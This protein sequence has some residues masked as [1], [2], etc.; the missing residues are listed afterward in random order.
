[1]KLPLSWLA[2]Y[3]DLPDLPVADLVET[4]GRFGLEVDAIDTPGAGVTGTTIARVL[5]WE[6]HPDA[7]RL[8]V[9]RITHGDPADGVGAGGDIVELVCGASNFDTGDVVVHAGVGGSIPGL[10]PGLVLEA[11]ELRGVVSNGMLCSA[12][13]LELGEDHDGIMVLDPDTP[14]GVD[15]HEVLPLGEP[16]IDL[17]VKGA[18]GDVLSVLGVAR[19][20]AAVLDVASVEPMPDL[21]PV[22]AE[23]PGDPV[24]VVIE[25]PAGCSHFAALTL[26]DVQVPAASPWWL[27]QR[28]A[29]VGV[30]AIS[31]LVDI[32]NYVMM[33][34]GQPMHAYDADRLGGDLSV[35]WADDGEVLVTLDDVE[36][37]L[38]TRDLVVADPGGPVGLAGVMGG[39]ATEVTADTRRLVLEAAIWDPPT[40]RHTARSLR[41]TSEASLRFER[42]VDP[43]GARRAIARAWELLVE[44]GGSATPVGLREAGQPI[45]ARETI[46]VD[47][48]RIRGLLGLDV[49]AEEQVAL[50][51]RAGVL[52]VAAGD[53]LTVTP[54]SWRSDLTRMADVAEEVAR[55]HGFDQIPA[56]L[57]PLLQGGGLADDQQAERDLRSAVLAFG[58]DEVITRPFVGDDHLRGVVPGNDRVVLANP[59]TQDAAAMRPSLLEGLLGVVRRN[60]GQSRPGVA[61]VEFGRIFRRE[62]GPLDAVLD[63]LTPTDA[64][65]WRWTLPPVDTTTAGSAGDPGAADDRV[66]PTQPR[67]VGVAL[68]GRRATSSRLDSR[69]WTV[70]EALAVFDEVA[71]R[72]G[73]TPDSIRLQRVPVARDGFHPHRTVAL[74]VEGHDGP[75]EV[76]VVGQLH[77]SEASGRDLPEP[78]VVG[79]LVL[80]PWLRA[81]AVG[82][83]PIVEV[84][85]VTRPAMIV[86]VAV[87]AA[88]ELAWADVEAAIRSAVGDLLED[89]RVFDVYRGD[90]LPEGHRSIA[91]RLWLRAADRAMDG[92]DEARVLADV[93]QAV[94]GAGARM[95]R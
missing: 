52:A 21:P 20:L 72:L 56:A 80:E 36:R 30:R 13:E 2:R 17:E 28:L 75:V 5:D 82:R 46:E 34:L 29:Q 64:D 44:I 50:L 26:D 89:C 61:V 85:L 90:P 83:D 71:R 9:V 24:E 1:M 16:V 67:A 95:R 48:G 45:T 94:A 4:M 92:D 70:P 91:A 33:E 79:E 19:D 76:G 93:E 59:L 25:A 40:I 65:D 10:A 63:A 60:V 87:E 14:V 86:D 69:T 37:A 18:R 6:P 54:P 39:D 42:G 84:A 38:T 32:T 41:L 35:R 43:A 47:A 53:T 68:Q 74:Q 73:P 57:P 22:P 78:V 23:P 77:P 49:S 66:L 7:D 81:L 55:L 11:R 8:R 62:G 12:R 58:L 88:D 15:V 27:R 31:P 51:A 3:L